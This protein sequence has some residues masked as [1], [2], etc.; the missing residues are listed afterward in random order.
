MPYQEKGWTW[1]WIG[2]QTV[3]QATPDLPN[4]EIEL[5]P[6]PFVGKTSFIFTIALVPPGPPNWK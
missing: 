6:H 4:E 2:W 5:D 3:S 1:E